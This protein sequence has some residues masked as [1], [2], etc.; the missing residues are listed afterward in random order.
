V[1]GVQTCALP[2]SH[3]RRS[4]A[5]LRRRSASDA[6]GM[7]TSTRQLHLLRADRNRPTERDSVA[8]RGSALARVRAVRGGARRRVPRPEATEVAFAVFFRTVLVDER[9]TA[10]WA[11]LTAE[12]VPGT[13][14]ECRALPIHL[15]GRF[16]KDRSD[17]GRCR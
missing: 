14:E 2:I 7:V 11:E 10:E 15:G 4:V 9:L 3:R 16:E 12:G 6:S 8:G 1:T 17:R 5:L 13:A